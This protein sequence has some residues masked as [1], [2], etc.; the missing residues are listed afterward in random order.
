MKI[1]NA[2]WYQKNCEN[3][4]IKRDKYWAKNAARMS[5]WRRQKI[6]NV[7]FDQYNEMLLAQNMSCAI[8]ER[9]Q[10]SFKR[11]LAVDHDHKTGEIRGLLCHSC[12]T[13][14]GSLKDD[15]LLVDKASAYLRRSKI[16]LVEEA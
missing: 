7:S 6:H 5:G 10:S 3:H 12:N 1:D 11:T 13:A 15:Y 4:K 2:I 9:H 8:C 14:I 16:K